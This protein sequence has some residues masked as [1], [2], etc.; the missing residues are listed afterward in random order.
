M[1]LLH[2]ENLRPRLLL[3]KGRAIECGL[4]A[5]AADG[6]LCSD[7]IGLAYQYWRAAQHARLRLA[8]PAL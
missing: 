7:W 6:G 2:R 1:P 8:V 4:E 5:G 3:M